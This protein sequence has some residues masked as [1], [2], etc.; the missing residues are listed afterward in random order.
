MRGFVEL[1]SEYSM[2]RDREA[3]G[4]DAESPSPDELR[5]LLG[6][7]RPAVPPEEARSGPQETERREPKRPR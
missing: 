7:R 1:V 4:T 6:R 5:L 2:T 3:D